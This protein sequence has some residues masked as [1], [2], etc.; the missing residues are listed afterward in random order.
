MNKINNLFLKQKEID[1]QL[2]EIRN[3]LN[4]LNK[5]DRTVAQVCDAIQRKN[6]LEKQ[7]KEIRKEISLVN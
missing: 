6:E 3:F 5:N 2:K 4:F 1:R 7:R